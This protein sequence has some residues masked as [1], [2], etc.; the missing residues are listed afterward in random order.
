MNLLICDGEPVKIVE[1]GG[2]E[3]PSEKRHGPQT[4][5]LARSLVFACRAQNEQETQPASPMV[6]AAEFRTETPQP[7][8]CATPHPAPVGEARRDGLLN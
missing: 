2:V 1:A 8:Y 7:A 4:T 3:P 6:L 5:C